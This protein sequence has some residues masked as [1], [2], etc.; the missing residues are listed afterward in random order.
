MRAARG[1]LVAIAPVHPLAF[2][3]G[4]RHRPLGA[5]DR[6][7]EPAAL[8]ALQA[9]H[10]DGT[11]GCEERAQHARVRSRDD[12]EIEPVSEHEEAP[13]NGER[14]L[15]GA[16]GVAAAAAGFTANNVLLWMMDAINN[17]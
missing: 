12:A 14:G 17:N 5:L 7:R 1:F 8:K 2:E 9:G 11:R 15:A 3:F 10:H 13:T 16:A 6:H 4:I